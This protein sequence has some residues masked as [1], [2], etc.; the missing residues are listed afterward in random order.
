VESIL[1]TVTRS[2]NMRKGEAVRVDEE[3]AGGGDDDDDN[4]DTWD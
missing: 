3:E 2:Y 4:V 1:F